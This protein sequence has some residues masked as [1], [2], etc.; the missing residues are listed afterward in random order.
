MFFRRKFYI[1]KNEFV[2]AFNA[3]FNKNNL[4]NQLKHGARLVGRWM[5]PKDEDSTE[6]FAIWEY[7]SYDEYVEVENNVRNDES[8]LQRVHEW[9]E[10]HGG[11][12]FVIRHY[13]LEVR[14]EE[15]KTT[16]N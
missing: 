4:P 8:H 11:R 14:N 13:L 15:I 9:Y 12:D 16:L 1:V 2:E 5:I 6:I 7:D 3:H 10:K